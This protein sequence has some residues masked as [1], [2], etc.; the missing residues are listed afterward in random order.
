MPPMCGAQV[1]SGQRDCAARREATAKGAD[2]DRIALKAFP[3]QALPPQAGHNCHIHDSVAIIADSRS[4]QN[5]NC[6]LER[7]LKAVVSFGPAFP[8]WHK[9]RSRQAKV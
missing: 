4:N 2:C 1:R 5:S 9:G 8:L 7:K 3:P 6:A